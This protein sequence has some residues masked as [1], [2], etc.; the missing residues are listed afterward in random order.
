M[1]QEEFSKICTKTERVN[2]FFKEK[3]RVQEEIDQLIENGRNYK[4]EV[5]EVK[6]WKV[7]GK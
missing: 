7:S 4:V 1:I 5:E 6:E 2:F 3:L